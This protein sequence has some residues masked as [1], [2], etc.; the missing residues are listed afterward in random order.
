MRLSVKYG[1]RDGRI[2]ATAQIP[3]SSLVVR[4]CLRADEFQD[5][6][7]YLGIVRDDTIA[8][9]G[10]SFKKL[11]RGLKRF[12]KK[13]AASKVFKGIAK[14]V[15]NPIFRALIPPQI[16]LALA[17]AEKAAKALGAAKRGVP[18]AAAALAKA[19]A[20]ARDG[21]PIVK[22]GLVLAA[23]AT[24]VKPS[25]LAAEAAS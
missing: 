12:A 21:D 16:A 13:V 14:V 24:G 25:S 1:V 3:G 11:S 4:A 6:L 23:Q 22:Q 9:V 15:N 19:V 2:I 8:G 17:I 7:D 10:F 18:G 5:V 20:Q